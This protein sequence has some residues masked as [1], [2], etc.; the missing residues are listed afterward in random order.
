M[1]TDV[2]SRIIDKI[3]RQILVSLQTDARLSNAALA[4]KV[5]LTTSSVHE[6]VKKLER[7]GIIKGY[8][9]VVNAE[10]LGKPIIAFIH[11]T[12]GAASTDYLESK[13]S[14]RKICQDEPDVLE[15]HTVAGEDCYILK[16]RASSPG[17]LERLIER[18]RCKAQVSR[19]TTNIVLSTLK[20][21]T[22]ILP[23][24]GG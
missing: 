19:T 11:L 13:K 2:D 18:M 12:V 23:A 6:R 9:A 14:V 5:G 17:D 7:K 20:E 8:V 24:T 3:D 15:C 1:A 16:A 22:Q 4:G 21:T 10:A